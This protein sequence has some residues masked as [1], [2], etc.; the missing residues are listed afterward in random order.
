M[1]EA[2]AREY[3]KRVRRLYDQLG[4]VTENETAFIRRL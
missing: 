4:E 3:E 2:E 1:P